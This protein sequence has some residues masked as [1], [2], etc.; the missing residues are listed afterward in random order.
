MSEQTDRLQEQLESLRLDYL[1][2]N[3]EPLATQA[4]EKHWTHADYLARL[5][6]GQ[7][8]TR[9][10]RSIQRRIKAAGFPVLKTLE[11]FDWNWPKKI[12]RPL[13]QNLMRLGFIEQK[14]NVVLV[15][16]VGLGTMPG[17]G[18]CRVV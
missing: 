11:D 12:N 3:Y 17:T 13:V 16:G 10:Q 18:L 14:A 15:G 5:I 6:D 9:E 8:Q 7:T 4:A 1:A 2:E